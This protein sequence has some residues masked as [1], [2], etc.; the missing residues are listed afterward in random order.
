[1]SQNCHYYLPP[2]NRPRITLDKDFNKVFKNED[3]LAYHSSIRKYEPTPLINLSKLAKSL[4][5][6]D[7]YLKDESSRF[8]QNTFKILG[9]SFAIHK[10]LESIPADIP[11]V[12]QRTATMA[13]QLPGRP[14]AISKKP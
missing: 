8:R 13:G 3:P 4:D 6:K 12:L 7:L 10:Y 11:S 5:I 2:E 14:G 9:A 1:M